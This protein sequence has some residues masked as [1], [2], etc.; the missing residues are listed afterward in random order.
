VVVT[1]ALCADYS[2]SICRLN[3]LV[4]GCRRRRVTL[5]RTFFKY[6]WRKTDRRVILFWGG[7]SVKKVGVDEVNCR[8]SKPM[9]KR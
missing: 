3:F 2:P 6:V 5:N 1:D 4:G 8:E 9:F 7:G